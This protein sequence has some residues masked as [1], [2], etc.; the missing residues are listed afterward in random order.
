LLKSCSCRSRENSC[1]RSVRETV[2]RGPKQDEKRCQFPGTR[3]QSRVLSFWPPWVRN[4]CSGSCKEQTKVRFGR[5]LKCQPN[6]SLNLR[7]FETS[8]STGRG[9]RRPVPVCNCFP[10]R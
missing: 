4:F 8:F 7:Y 9:S 3:F 1:R 2:L 6:K 10:V 5:L